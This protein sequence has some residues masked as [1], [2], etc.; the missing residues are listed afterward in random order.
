MGDPDVSVWHYA[1]HDL[2]K[3]MRYIS[4]FLTA[5][6]IL[7]MDNCVKGRGFLM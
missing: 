4:F 7:P 6:L 1:F 3:C 5:I 2:L